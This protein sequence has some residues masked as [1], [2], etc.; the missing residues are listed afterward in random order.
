MRSTRLSAILMLLASTSVSL[1]EPGFDEKYQRDFD[2]FNP[3]NQYQP[4][5]LPTVRTIRLTP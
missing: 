2:I 4:G 3:I 1:A 5:S